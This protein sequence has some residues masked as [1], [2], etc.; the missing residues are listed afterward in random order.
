VLA[1]IPLQQG[2]KGGIYIQNL[3]YAVVLFSIVFTSALIF[4]VDK[5]QL[6]SVYR[7]VLGK[8]RKPATVN[9]Q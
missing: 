7:A 3:T 1:S 8:F 4:L 5:T 2:V 9:H 6:A